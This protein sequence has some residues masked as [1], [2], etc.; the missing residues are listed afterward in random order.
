[1]INSNKSW[2]APHQCWHFQCSLNNRKNYFHRQA[3]DGKKNFQSRTS[4]EKIKID[5][6]KYI[7]KRGF[8]GMGLSS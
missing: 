4:L 3:Y 2:K 5:K 8:K 7:G 1:M 6:N